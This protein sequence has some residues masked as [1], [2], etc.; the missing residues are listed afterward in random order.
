L[1]GHT[2]ETLS[3]LK[4]VISFAHEEITLKKYDDYANSA[5]TISKKAVVTQGLMSML[6]FLFMF[7]FYIYSY[8]IASALLQYQVNNPTTGA[9]Y[10]IGEI[11]TVA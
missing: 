2:E 11:V 3:A 6:F 4:L 9:P 7:G 1:G 5:M 8:G 10:V